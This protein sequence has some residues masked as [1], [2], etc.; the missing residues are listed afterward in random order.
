MSDREWEKNFMI[1]Q[2]YATLVKFVG[3]Q[4]PGTCKNICSKVKKKSFYFA[5]Q[6]LRKKK[7]NL[8]ASFDFEDILFIP[9]SEMLYLELSL[10]LGIGK[11]D[12]HVALTHL[13]QLT[14]MAS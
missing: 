13:S 10:V 11:L 6:T 3:V 1:I 9:H 2:G 5:L 4:L 7:Q 12:F 8:I 14:L